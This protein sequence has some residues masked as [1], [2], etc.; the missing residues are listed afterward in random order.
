MQFKGPARKSG[1]FFC[2]LAKL[3]T[4]DPITSYFISQVSSCIQYSERQKTKA[5]WLELFGEI[6]TRNEIT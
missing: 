4:A 5:E 3:T 2:W 1:A 6:N